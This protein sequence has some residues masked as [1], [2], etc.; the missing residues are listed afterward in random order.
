MKKFDVEES[1]V[2]RWIL[3]IGESIMMV[4][5][6]VGMWAIL[7]VV[8][9]SSVQEVDM[10]VYIVTAVVCY[11]LAIVAVPHI[12]LLRTVR[13]DRVVA[14]ACQTVLVHFV[15]LLSFL[16]LLKNV[17]IARILLVGFSLFFG[18]LL[19]AERLLVSRMV[20]R[21]RSNGRNLQVAILVGRSEEMAE[22]CEQMQDREYG[23]SIKGIFSDDDYQIEGVERLGGTKD[24][25]DFLSSDPN[26]NAVY[27]TMARMEKDDLIALYRYCENNLIRF[28]A[29]PMYLSYL[30]R[31]M[32]VSHL[33][34]TILLSPRRE[35]LRD[36]GNRMAKRI[37]DLVI[38]GLFLFTL[39]PIIYVIVAIIIKRQSPGPII[40]VQKRNGLNG[41]VFN[42]YK[43]RSM[44]VNDE[45]DTVQATEH[46]VRKFPFG[47]LMRRTNIDELPQFINVFLGDM[48]VVGPRPH[49][50][51]HTEEYGHIINRYMV[52]HW[53]KPGVTGWAQVNG[54]RGET[55][56][57][58][59]MERRV[60]ADI[61]Y[62]ENWTFWLDIRIIWRTFIDTLFGKGEN[63]Y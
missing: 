40:F 4:A 26:V 16:F 20:R 42:C 57:V 25:M 5:A 34:N 45:A 11:A 52:R 48:S 39:F 27:C 41:Q 15:L 33:G 3:T 51:L 2:L 22:L 35:P 21:F 17:A 38:S 28:Y 56:E 55:R 49:M 54:F 7:L 10:Q 1:K 63:A 44:H 46:D 9:P 24:V 12:L 32:T 47:D 58:E 29:L 6:L 37:L 50:L 13:G 61:W 14:R 18:V 23:F 62:I 43:F 19:V 36:Y 59:Q 60:R 31:R 8:D 53:A 30:R